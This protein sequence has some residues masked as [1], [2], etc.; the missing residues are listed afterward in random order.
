MRRGRRA[1]SCL[2][3][4]IPLTT[5]AQHKEDGVHRRA[6]WHP[7]VVAAQRV[8]WPRRQQWFHLCPQRVWQPPAV[9]ADRL[10]RL[11]PIHLF[12][13]LQMGIER[14]VS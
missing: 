11:L 9:I 10:S 7:R 14:I 12:H 1:K 4:R 2:V 6:V 3:Q 5:G 8:F 13:A